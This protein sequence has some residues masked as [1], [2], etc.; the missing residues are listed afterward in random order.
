MLHNNKSDF[1]ESLQRYSLHDAQQ[2]LFLCKTLNS[3]YHGSEYEK[4]KKLSCQKLQGLGLRYLMCSIL[5]MTFIKIVQIKAP[6]SIL[7][8]PR[9]HMIL[10][11][12]IHRR[13]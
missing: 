8:T 3:G 12:L 13:L 7:A 6:G 10:H 4:L 9:V 2:K 11:K 5:Q 1:D